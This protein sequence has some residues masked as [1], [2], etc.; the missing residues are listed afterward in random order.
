[1]GFKKFIT[2]SRDY[3]GVHWGDI[4]LT[5]QNTG[6]WG[7]NTESINLYDEDVDKLIAKLINLRKAPSIIFSINPSGC[8]PSERR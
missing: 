5:I 7:E 1:M 2:V 4:E 6:E 8:A 3:D